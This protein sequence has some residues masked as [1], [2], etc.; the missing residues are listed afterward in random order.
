MPLNLLLKIIAELFFLI[1]LRP[2]LVIELS[3][4]LGSLKNCE[5]LCMTPKNGTIWDIH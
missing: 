4:G 2:F 3:Y 5:I 1:N